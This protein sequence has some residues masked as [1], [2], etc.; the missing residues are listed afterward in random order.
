MNIVW[1]DGY[2]PKWENWNPWGHLTLFGKLLTVLM[3]L[4]LVGAMLWMSAPYVCCNG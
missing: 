2:S 1:K 3:V 4:G